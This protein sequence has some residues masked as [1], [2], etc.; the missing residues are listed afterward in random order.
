MNKTE[1]F[2]GVPKTSNKRT[3][4]RKLGLKIGST[5][6]IMILAVFFGLLVWLID[7]ILDFYI[8]YADSNSFIDILLTEMPSL[9]LYIRLLI[10]GTFLIFGVLI[11]M[12]NKKREIAEKTLVENEEKYRALYDN[13]PL[14][15]QSLNENGN[16]IDV[17]PMWLQTLGYAPNEVIGQCDPS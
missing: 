7:A 2:E 9:E 10:V 8:F 3:V 1:S 15:Y 6:S 5:W 17:N 16:I 4:F 12:V 13:S 11:S 14:S